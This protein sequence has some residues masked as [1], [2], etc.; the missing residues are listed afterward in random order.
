MPIELVMDTFAHCKRDGTTHLRLAEALLE[1]SNTLALRS[2][3]HLLELL[4]R[5]RAHRL[6]SRLCLENARL[7]RKGIDALTRGLRWLLLQLH[8]ESAAK[9]ELSDRFQL[10]CC[11]GDHS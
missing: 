11:K 1:G 5:Q 6:G 9:L 7:F 8:V 2:V 3:D 10:L 4:H